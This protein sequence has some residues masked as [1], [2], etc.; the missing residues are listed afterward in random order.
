M[1]RKYV[2]FIIEIYFLDISKR[3]LTNWVEIH[4]I[5]VDPKQ[6]QPSILILIVLIIRIHFT[7]PKPGNSA[8]IL[9]PRI[10]QILPL[11]VYKK[12]NKN[13]MK[14]SIL[15]YKHKQK[16]KVTAVSNT[17]ATT[18]ITKKPLHEPCHIS[19]LWNQQNKGGRYAA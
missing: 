1:E 17:K 12:I 10:Q 2:E 4:L 5:L 13:A 16:Y 18:E 19:E 9:E 7:D 11:K 6:I 3:A 15:Q 14:M 8:A